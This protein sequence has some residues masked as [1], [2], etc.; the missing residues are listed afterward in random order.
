MTEER[1]V[2]GWATLEDGSRVR[3][4]QDEARALLEGAE[5][6][7]ARKA[8]LMPTT[9]EAVGAM[10]DARDRLRRLGWG[11]GCY[12]PKDGSLF[13]VI[14]HGSSGIFTGFYRGEW[15]KG[16]ARVEDE[17]MHPDG[18]LWKSLDK[19]TAWEEEMRKASARSTAGH[20]A[21][22]GKMASE[23]GAADDGEKKCACPHYDR[24]EC[25][26]MRLRRITGGPVP[27]SEDPCDCDCHNAHDD[28]MDEEDSQ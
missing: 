10:F 25:A 26:N 22:L 14:Q 17:I 5:A 13:A 20:I 16:F 2:E 1:I 28:E 11:D 19:L 9:K 8:E 15:P 27:S 18:Y 3:L 7:E 21:R 12:C 6:N 4:T 23:L 24:Y